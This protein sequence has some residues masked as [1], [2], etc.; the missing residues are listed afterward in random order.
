MFN[1]YNGIK[2]ALNEAELT[3]AGRKFLEETL[4]LK[5]EELYENV[6]RLPR[7]LTKWKTE[8]ATAVKRGCK[9]FNLG[10]EEQYHLESGEMLVAEPEPDIT[11]E[12]CV[13][14]NNEA[15]LWFRPYQCSE[16]IEGIL[17]L[18]GSTHYYTGLAEP[19][20]SFLVAV[21][22]H[23]VNRLRVFGTTVGDA[24]R[25][26]E[27]LSHMSES[28]DNACNAFLEKNIDE[29]SGDYNEFLGLTKKDCPRL[30]R[31]IQGR[32]KVAVTGVDADGIVIQEVCDQLRQLLLTRVYKVDRIDY[33]EVTDS[34]DRIMLDELLADVELMLVN[35]PIYFSIEVE[36][37]VVHISSTTEETAI[38]EFDIKRQLREIWKTGTATS[39]DTSALGQL[40]DEFRLQEI[41]DSFEEAQKVDQPKEVERGPIHIAVKKYNVERTDEAF[42]VTYLG[43]DC[44]GCDEMTTVTAL[45]MLLKEGVG[46]RVLNIDPSISSKAFIDM[47]TDAYKK[48]QSRE[49]LIR[50]FEEAKPMGYNINVGQVTVD[51]EYVKGGSLS[52]DQARMAIKRI[53]LEKEF[54]SEDFRLVNI[55]QPELRTEF[56][57]L[58]TEAANSVNKAREIF[59]IPVRERTEAV[60]LS[61][62]TK[63]I[64]SQIPDVAFKHLQNVY[65][66][67][68]DGSKFAATARRYADGAFHGDIMLPTEFI[69]IKSTAFSTT[70]V[71]K[72]LWYGYGVQ[73]R[74]RDIK[75]F[76]GGFVV[77]NYN[78]PKLHNRV[79]YKV[80]ELE[81]YVI[82]YN[83]SDC[84]YNFKGS[85]LE[86][87]SARDTL[88]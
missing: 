30:Y 77:V 68:L 19:L 31:I 1:V 16:D 61:P 60:E 48:E 21:H 22:E 84:G 64:K 63:A 69:D 24:C 70:N 4:S 53:M 28:F 8:T 65:G 7:F 38:D 23:G 57:A 56:G 43:E 50:E 79:L 71:S 39:I 17:R 58:L 74:P 59:E 33:S 67:F 26:I 47:L 12:C 10:D 34:A 54:S 5:G 20:T 87:M 29:F 25:H 3:D 46:E 36:N 62:I 75:C 52:R 6:K 72:L 83:A 9:E 85:K 32:I 80:M 35:T 37:G 81:G 78:D 88:L 73:E 2:A 13:I 82:F 76:G 44:D 11:V 15:R 41:W 18:N 45:K 14:D 66:P 55:T 40:N 42:V 86:F 51:V 27:G 49:E